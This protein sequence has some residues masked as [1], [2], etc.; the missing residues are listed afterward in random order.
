[1]TRESTL[2]PFEPGDILIGC[3]LLNDPDDDHAGEGRIRQYDKNMQVKGELWTE[4]GGHYVGGLEFDRN[5]LLW[6]FNDH[7]VIHVDP[8]T[9][10]QLPLAEF[11]ARSFYSA[12]FA[13]DGSIYLGEHENAREPPAGLEKY[14]TIKFVLTPDTGVLGC[15]NIYKF[16]RDWQFEKEYEVENEPEFLGFKGVTHSTLHPSGK[17][18]AYTT[19]TGKR[20]MRYDVVSEQQMPDL[21]VYGSTGYSAGDVTAGAEARSSEVVIAVKYLPHG[22]LLVTHRTSMDMV[23]KAGEVVRQYPFD[24]TGWSN[25]ALC[26]DDRHVLVN[27]IWDGIFIKVDLETGEIVNKVDTGFKGP[28]RCVAG[29][30]VYPGCD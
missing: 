21:I 11:P 26:H 17:F 28:N 15:G 14:T 2:Q 20:I 16:N 3:T 6:A 13:D 30:A 7:S 4:G 22:D 27:S 1:M 29:I 23:N 18:I 12:S 24:G 8:N 5:G 25:I 10:C 9:G 19:E